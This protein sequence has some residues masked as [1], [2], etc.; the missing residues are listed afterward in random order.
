MGIESINIVNILGELISMVPLSVCYQSW[1]FN[2]C[3]MGSLFNDIAKIPQGM[4]KQTKPIVA[5]NKQG[6]SKNLESKERSFMFYISNN[7]K[8]YINIS[9]PFR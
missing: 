4:S 7:P 9:F 5:F 8:I 2:R 6:N 1:R 3:R